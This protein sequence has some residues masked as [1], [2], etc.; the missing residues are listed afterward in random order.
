MKFHEMPNGD[1]LLRV[2]MNPCHLFHGNDRIN[3]GFERVDIENVK[4]KIFLKIKGRLNTKITSC[5]NHSA[6]FNSKVSISQQI[7]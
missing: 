7:K 5:A 1:W 4:M 3:I 6:K 2:R